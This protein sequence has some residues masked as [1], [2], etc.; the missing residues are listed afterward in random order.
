MKV[1]AQSVG[2]IISMYSQLPGSPPSSAKEEAI[3]T[4]PKTRLSIMDKYEVET[5]VV[6]IPIDPPGLGI[7]GKA[8]IKVTRTANDEISSIT[9]KF[10]GRFVG[11]AH[12]PLPLIDE[13]LEELDRCV[14]DLGF[15]G[16]LMLTNIGGRPLDL[17]DFIPLYDR[18]MTHHI[19]I[20]LHPTYPPASQQ[21][22]Y[23]RD[24]HLSMLMGWPF[25]ISLALARLIF[26]GVLDRCNLKIVAHL[27]GGMVPF[28]IK[29]ISSFDEFLMIQRQTNKAKPA[30]YYLKNIYFD[31]AINRSKEAL[32]YLCSIIRTDHVVFAS[33]YPFGPETGEAYIRETLAN[34]KKLGLN[35]SDISRIED[36]NARM[37]LKLT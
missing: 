11:V 32:Q 6:C 19:P 7:K 15:R 25:E 36:Q 3:F 21:R 31:T 2:S 35:S 23:E 14:N 34:I 9:N 13:S 28:Y 12:L 24:F 10:P 29:R 1:L 18:I 17:P 30:I 37:I 8:A 22:K 20:L 26:S 4:D 33:D 16:V 5:Q 27:S